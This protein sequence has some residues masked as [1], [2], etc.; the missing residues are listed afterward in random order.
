MGGRGGTGGGNVSIDMQAG[1]HARGAG[2]QLGPIAWGDLV[3]YARAGTPARTDHV[4]HPSLSDWTP[5]GAIPGLFDA[6]TPERPVPPAPPAP[7][8]VRQP[9]S[10]VV[11]PTPQPATPAPA[12]AVSAPQAP[13]TPHVAAQPAAPAATPPARG[14]KRGGMIAAVVVLVIALLGGLGTAAWWFLLRDGATLSLGSEAGPSLGA[15]D[16]TLPD[17]EDLIATEQWGEVPANHVMVALAEGEDRSRAEEVAAEM[18]GQVVGEVEFINLY[19]VQ[20]ASTSE[21]EL[22][23]AIETAEALEGVEAA[24]PMDQIELDAEIWG[25]R[26]DPYSDPMYSGPAGDGYRA[27]GVSKAWSYIN[28]AG[29]ELND[30]RVG[31]VDSGL[32][33]PGEGAE[34]EFGGDVKVD[35]PDPDAGEVTN[36]Q[37]YKDGTTNQAGTHATGVATIIGGDPNNGGPAGV[38]G[39]LGKK[40]TI[41]MINMYGGKYGDTQTTSDPADIT[42]QDWSPGHSYSIGALVALTKQVESGAKVIN[43]S[44]GN[45]EADPKDVATYT[46]FFTKMA[47]LHPDV[48]FVCSG[49]NGGK[50]MDGATRYPSGLKLPNMITVGA[51]NND[52]TRAEYGDWA[53][54]DYEITLSAPGTNAVVGM[55]SQGGPVQQNGSSFAAPQVTAA[56]AMLKALNPK[57]TAGEIKDILVA[58]ARDGVPNTS[59]DPTAT[60][61]LVPPEMGG[62]ILAVD[63]AVLQVINDLREDKGLDPLDEKTLELLGVVDA[64]AITGDAGEYTVRGIVGAVGSKGTALK[65][66]V[67]AENSAI[68]GKTEQRLD[69]AGDVEWDVTLPEDKG[70]IKVTRLDSGA[71]SLITIEEYDIGGH[72][73]GTFT[74][75]SIQVDPEIES[76]EGCAAALLTE[77]VG[78]PIPM[79]LDLTVDEAGNGSGTMFIDIASVMEDG[80]GE[81]VAVTVTK[82]GNNVTFILSE[83]GADMSGTVTR[84]GDTLVMTGGLSASGEGWSMVGAFTLSKPMPQ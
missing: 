5:A 84:S 65:I 18:G 54:D 9:A 80:E 14:K 43:C 37:V 3:G 52:G 77:L 44:W 4:W 82:S 53:S 58:T 8:R 51:L 34:S 28:G 38:A 26:S 79:T 12:P 19:Q 46:R 29:I 13:P 41:S 23:A 61:N 74:F 73:D 64:V 24:Y 50:E 25:V 39:P 7:P 10:P 33:K 21:A 1:W 69:A 72:W 42:K 48:L 27:V 45:S 81:P 47:E 36:P 17:P 40:L 68:G 20:T 59:G 76:E 32:Y 30:V 62:K 55:A 11:P 2:W 75:T 78:T 83:G 49:G 16:T 63:Q 6:P 70:T 60:S 15:A 66:E 56:A 35:F 57:L 22:V 67:F 31:V 71:S